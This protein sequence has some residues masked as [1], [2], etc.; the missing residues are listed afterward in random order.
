MATKNRSINPHLPPPSP[1]WLHFSP[2]FPARLLV[3]PPLLLLIPG[4]SSGRRA[5]LFLRAPG[6][7]GSHRSPHARQPREASGD[8]LHAPRRRIG[9]SPFPAARAVPTLTHGTLGRPKVK[10]CG[11]GRVRDGGPKSWTE[12]GSGTSG[13]KRRDRERKGRVGGTRR[14]ASPRRLPGARLRDRSQQLGRHRGCGTFTLYW[15]PPGPLSS[16]VRSGDW[17]LQKLPRGVLAAA[18]RA[19]V[20]SPPP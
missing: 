5:P 14:T 10:D 13:R 20:A 16:E 18:P 4:S 11:D 1:P 12:R 7:A 9:A 2:G 17:G 3:L 6:V 15:F 19:C 8:R